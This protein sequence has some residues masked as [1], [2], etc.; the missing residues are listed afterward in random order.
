MA[1]WNS[2]NALTMLRVLINDVSSTTYTD[3]RLKQ[4]MAVSAL[5]INQDIDFDISYTVDV[6]TPDIIPDPSTDVVYTNF[7]VMKAACL[8][9]LSTYRTKALMEGIAAKCG[10]AALTV[11][12]NL[13][14]FKELLTMGPCAAYESMKEDY[15]LAD[16]S[17]CRAI[18]TPFTGNNFDPESL[19][20]VYDGNYSNQ[21]T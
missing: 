13:R 21:Y 20:Y 18:L 16:G 10:P 3:D 17:I 15:I 19:G 6:A 9:D 8:A 11:V 5:Y 14:G 4:M 1:T 2:T 12:G 7:M